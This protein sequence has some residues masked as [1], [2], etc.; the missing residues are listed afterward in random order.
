MCG[1]DDLEAISM[2]HF[3]CNEWGLDTISA[4]VSVAFVME[5]YEKGIITKEDTGGLEFKFGDKDIIVEIVPMI[6]KREGFGDVIAEGTMRMA[7]KF[8]KG[9]EHFAMHVKGL[10][11]PAYD[12]RAAKITGLAYATANRGGDHI[13]AW[14]EGPAFLSMPFMIVDDA[15]VGDP[16]R[17]IPE[18][19]VILKDF[20][21]AFQIF[22]A[23]GACK[24]MGIVMTA[25]DW[26]VLLS[27]LMGIEYTA[28]DFRKTGERIYNLEKVYNIRE[29]ATRADDTLPP[30]LLK[31]PLPEGPAKG[32]V[33]D[34]EPMLVSYYKFRGWDKEGKPTKEKLTDLGLE[35]VIDQIY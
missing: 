33:V 32:L 20:E 6:A 10:E 11:L 9:S 5:C 19:S 15:D 7:E 22:D 21:D 3:L 30:R 13:T 16:Q 2:A 18:K 31:D 25:E 28:K 12:S 29:G 24:F 35:W 34:L 17:E 26:A 4:G 8:G 14:I 1:V 23:V 27:N